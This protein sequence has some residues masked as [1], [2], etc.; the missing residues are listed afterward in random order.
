M[1]AAQAYN[2]DR[3]ICL[4]ISG[5]KRLIHT[6]DVVFLKAEGNYSTIVLASG[7]KHL[8]SKS[9]KKALASFPSQLFHRCHQSYAV[10]SR[11][12]RR[13]LSRDIVEVGTDTDVMS[14]PISRRR[15]KDFLSRF[16]Y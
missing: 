8:I 13:T 16:N 10:N 5:S 6:T 3:A 15:K 12:V 11:Y 4:T 2:T 1:N 14:L 7:Q 9:L